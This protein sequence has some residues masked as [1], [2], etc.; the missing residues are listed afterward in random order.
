MLLMQLG[1]WNTIGIFPISSTVTVIIVVERMTLYNHV[2]LRS[3]LILSGRPHN[4]LWTVQPVHYQLLQ[5][6]ETDIMLYNRS[7][8]R[9]SL[10]NFLILILRHYYHRFDIDLFLLRLLFL[11]ADI[12]TGLWYWIPFNTWLSPLSDH[13]LRLEL[14]VNDLWVLLH[15]LFCIGFVLAAIDLAM[16]VW[17]RGWRHLN[18][19][20]FSLRRYQLWDALGKHKTL[21]YH[22]ELGFMML[23]FHHIDTLRQ[24][25]L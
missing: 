20:F 18:F 16:H 5:A 2:W 13:D 9:L 22:P 17:V 3:R 11:Q 14:T 6:V 21:E 10:H 4:R 24:E 15:W 25:L 23:V 1:D 8:G 7:C 12:Y 19:I